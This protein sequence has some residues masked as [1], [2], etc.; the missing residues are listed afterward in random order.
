MKF[1]DYWKPPQNIKTYFSPKQEKVLKQKYGFCYTV[2]TVFSILILLAPFIVFLWLAPK[3]AF[4]PS[5]TVGNVFGALGGI[6]GLIGSFSIGVGFVNIFMALIKQY[7]GH[8][9]TII[10][11]IC[12][13]LLDIAGWFL[14]YMVK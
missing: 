9:I 8:W 4:E 11:I 3:N 6:V 13:L 10:T 2:H 7:L 5:T 1:N 12:G 14:F